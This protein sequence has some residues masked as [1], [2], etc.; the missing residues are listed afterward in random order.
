MKVSKSKKENKVTFNVEGSLSLSNITGIHSEFL[1]NSKDFESVLIKG[2]NIT[3]IDLS[4][5][6]LVYSLRK[7]K[8]LE[9]DIKLNEEQ[10]SILN[11]AGIKE[12]NK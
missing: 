10:Q 7:S 6:Q 11:I 9:L 1:N 5:V 8:K 4:F 12:F 3:D 2:D